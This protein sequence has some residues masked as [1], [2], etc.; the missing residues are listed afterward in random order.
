MKNADSRSIAGNLAAA[1]GVK[2]SP[3]IR[4]AITREKTVNIGLFNNSGL[5]LQRLTFNEAARLIR[6]DGVTA[7]DLELD[8]KLSSKAGVTL[9][10]GDMLKDVWSGGKYLPT[11]YTN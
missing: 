2:K 4:E 1:F 7:T 6:A 8:K 5:P 11:K 10:N 3:S 9:S